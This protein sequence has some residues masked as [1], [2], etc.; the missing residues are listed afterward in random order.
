MASNSGNPQASLDHIVYRWGFSS[1]LGRQGMGPI[2]TTLNERELRSWHGELENHVSMDRSLA[3]SPSWSASRVF[4]KDRYALIL[5]EASTHTGNRDG[6]NAHV[7]LDPQCLVDAHHMLA[8][9]WLHGR[10]S[11]GVAHPA[12]VLE[13]V[14]QGERLGLLRVR[15]DAYDLHRHEAIRTLARR[16]ARLLE[17]VLAAVLRHP[18]MAYT[19]CAQDVGYDIVPLLWG[20]FDLAMGLAAG[21]WTFST[22]ETSDSVIKPRFV[23]V[24][25]WPSAPPSRGRIR[26][27]PY[28]EPRAGADV[29]REAAAV[30]VD[31][32]LRNPWPVVD[33]RLDKLDAMVHD[34]PFLERAAIVADR[35]VDTRLSHSAPIGPGGPHRAP[36]AVAEDADADADADATTVLAPPPGEDEYRTDRSPG[37]GP[38]HGHDPYRPTADEDD[39]SD[40]DRD[41]PGGGHREDDVGVER[42]EHH[43]R[44]PHPTPRGSVIV[45]GFDA[46]SEAPFG[47]RPGM[48]FDRPPPRHGPVIPPHPA[49]PPPSTV[50]EPP[51]TGRGTF[52]R[53]A[54]IALDATAEGFETLIEAGDELER[55]AGRASTHFT[56]LLAHVD[57]ASLAAAVM[58]VE[59]RLLWH[60]LGRL[61]TLL[62]R[63]E[64]DRR[65]SGRTTKS[66]AATFV[67]VL[68]RFDETVEAVHECGFD[69]V[70]AGDMLERMTRIV[71]RTV[72]IQDFGKN[73]CGTV[74]RM[75]TPSQAWRDYQRGLVRG[76]LRTKY[77]DEFL[78]E[79]GWRDLGSARFLPKNAERRP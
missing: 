44:E 11:P 60:T 56:D 3:R 36:A 20:L 24:P 69:S 71:I 12:P 2:A 65:R 75:H 19:L 5:R 15:P 1:L 62:A 67:Q 33:A 61:D 54:W 27:D 45:R 78:A 16:D 9:V 14:G 30:L 48:P 38:G 34:V 58:L 28:E 40:P 31:L 37:Y 59:P 21:N 76:V 23:L 10:V 13:T 51:V 35:A 52:H 46:A 4:H 50:L 64:E 68:T 57:I 32:Y 17:I 74:W 43:D 47:Q 8:A 66:V 25:K 41:N 55:T 42:V 18:D 6:N 77:E 22:Y 79:W 49:G 53:P 70:T 63:V 72:K 29:F 39:P 26:I 7:L 73:L